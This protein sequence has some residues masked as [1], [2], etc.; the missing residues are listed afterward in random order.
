M[1]LPA[2]SRA[3]L[4]TDLTIC[5]ILN[6]M[7]QVSG[8]HGAVDPVRAVDGESVIQTSISRLRA[9]ATAVLFRWII[10]R[11]DPPYAQ[12]GVAESAGRVTA[13]LHSV[14]ERFEGSEG[15]CRPS[16]GV[17]DLF[18]AGATLSGARSE[19]TIGA[20]ALDVVRKVGAKL[21]SV[22][23]NTNVDG[24][25]IHADLHGE[26]LILRSNGTV[27]VIDFD[28]CGIGHYMLDIAS[29]LSSMYRRCAARSDIYPVLARRY[30]RGYEEVRPLPST[31]SLL[32]AFLIMR[33]MVILNFIIGSRNP[34]VAIWGPQRANGIIELMRS[35]LGGRSYPGVVALSSQT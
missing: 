33:D 2:S 19:R 14:A 13:Q 26:N 35:Y 1:P 20:D 18:D 3:Q 24:G 21:Q 6:G 10:G 4:T 27:A 32:E 31:F 25:M 29:V 8:A 17:R 28:D 7:W 15:F 16:W 11:V 22:V 34:T 5:R 9:P 23:P 12:R 30:L